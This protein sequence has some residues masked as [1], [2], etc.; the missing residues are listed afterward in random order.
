[1][2]WGAKTKRNK[3]QLKFVNGKFF[4]SGSQEFMRL[5]MKPDLKLI[6]TFPLTFHVNYKMLFEKHCQRFICY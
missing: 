4:S 6:I 2:V 1:M 5:D 3:E